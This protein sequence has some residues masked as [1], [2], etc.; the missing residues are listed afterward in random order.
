MSKFT[1]IDA[2]ATRRLEG[3]RGERARTGG[4]LALLLALTGACTREPSDSPAPEVSGGEAWLL[5]GTNDERFARVARQLRGFDVAMVE[6]GYRYGELYWAGQ[7]QN[8]EYAKYQIEKI[9]TAVSNGV[10]RRPKRGPSARMLDG[11]LAAIEEAIAAGDPALFAARYETLTTT[12]NA[13]HLAERVPFV[14]VQPPTVRLAP[15]GP[16]AVGDDDP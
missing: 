14:R 7:D 6:T 2:V 3:D 16:P 13:C 8:W 12:C 5:S 9:R 11:P 10:E 4:V 15:V 1:K